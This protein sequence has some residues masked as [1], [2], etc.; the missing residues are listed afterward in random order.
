MKTSEGCFDSYRGFFIFQGYLGTFI[1]IKKRGEGMTKTNIIVGSVLFLFVYA[2]GVGFKLAIADCTIPIGHNDYCSSCGP[3][4]EG[5]G[6]CDSDSE[7][8]SG[9]TCPQVSGTDTC[10]S[11][12]PSGKPYITSPAYGSTLTGSTVTFHWT[13]NGTPVDAWL[14]YVGTSVGASD[15]YISDWPH[16]NTY[17]TANR[18][19]TDRSWV[20]VRLVY[21]TLPML[22]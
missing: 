2:I 5:E 14:L 7:C 10:Q 16:P 4:A 1:N 20:Y 12:G 18:L 22:R 11:G 13:A 17:E 6:D 21:L 8:Q 9:L 3:C 15:I 19:P